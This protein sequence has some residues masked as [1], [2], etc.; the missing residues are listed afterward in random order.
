MWSRGESSSCIGMAWLVFDWMF[1]LNVICLIWYQMGQFKKRIFYSSSPKRD[2]STPK[3]WESSTPWI[4]EY[5]T[6]FVEQDN[7]AILGATSAQGCGTP[8]LSNWYVVQ[9]LPQHSINQVH[10]DDFLSR[11]WKPHTHWIPLT[12][13]NWI[14][15]FIHRLQN[16]LLKSCQMSQLLNSCWNLSLALLK[17]NYLNFRMTDLSPWILSVKSSRMML[18]SLKSIL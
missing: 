18:H 2:S 15:L 5:H 17:A 10:K 8:L 12:C 4:W 1:S 14:V 11:S 6:P 9:G 16:P 3:V 7:S 13:N